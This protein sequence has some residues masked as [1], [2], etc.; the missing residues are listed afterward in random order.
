MPFLIDNISSLLASNITEGSNALKT[1]FISNNHLESKK[2]ITSIKECLSNCSEFYMSVAFITLGGI[3]PLTQILYELEKRNI[4]GYI[5]TTDYLN[6]NDPGALEILSK[7]KNITLKMYLT[8]QDKNKKGEPGFHTKGY[9]FKGNEHNK[10]LYQ[11]IIGSSNLTSTAL[12]LN[13]EWNTQIS[14]S[15]DEKL[16]HDIFEEFKQLWTD[17]N[18]RDYEEVKDYYRHKY[19]IIKAQQK[20]AVVNNVIAF[21]T[22]QLKPNEMQLEFIANLKKLLN[23]RK[24][25]ALFISATGTGKTYASAFAIREIDPQK[26]L[27]VVHREQIA[28][29]SMKSYEIVFNGS[30]NLGLLSGNSK[31]YEDKDIVFATQQT[32]SKKEVYSKFKQDEFD[33]IVIDEAHRI[34]GSTYQ[35][36][37]SYFKPKLLLGM[38]ATPERTDDFDVYKAFDNNI[39]YEIRLQQALEYNFLCPF[40]YFGITDL[41]IDTDD[42]SK[43]SDFR[44]LCRK[45]RLNYI[46]EKLDLYG[47]D[48]DKVKG[49]IFCS[50]NDEAKELANL[51]NASGLY[52]TIALSGTNTQEE[53]DK[54]CEL[55]ESDDPES[56]LDYIFTV[57]IFN[58]GIDIP[59]VNQ[60]VM[61]RPTQSPIVFVQQLGRGLRKT[62][63]KEFVVIIDFIGNY[64]NNFMIPMALSGDRSYK[65]ENLRRFVHEGERII[66]GSSSIS[67]DAISKQKI[68]E[69][70]DSTNFSDLR[71]IKE[72]YKQLKQKVGRVP[73]IKDFELYGQMDVQC[74]FSNKN[75]HSYYTF[76]KKHDP[77]DYKTRIS[78]R[79]EQYINFITWKFAN[80]KRNLE[81]LAFKLMIE[82]EESNLLSKLSKAL[83]RELQKKETINITNILC[84]KYLRGYDFTFTECINGELTISKEFSSLLKDQAFKEILSEVIDYTIDKF[85]KEYNSSADTPFVLYKMY[86][87][88]DVER[89]LCWE[90]HLSNIGG[91][92]HDK[93]TNSFPI[94]VNY[95]KSDDISNTTNYQD[96]F[97]DKNTF[98]WVTR[99]KRSM[100]SPDVKTILN[101]ESNKVTIDLFIRKESASNKNSS[102]IK[103]KEGFKEFYY[104][105][106]VHYKKDTA[107]L[108]TM[109][110]TEEN[111]D[112][113]AVKMDLKLENRV[114]DDI[115][116][117][118]VNKIDYKNENN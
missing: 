93:K 44:Y 118:L 78:P 35:E 109:C 75:L 31:N 38:T 2:V 28:K 20:A 61:L 17:D 58:E 36:L 8:A 101:E 3:K 45:E 87:Y 32:L 24:E 41:Y 7:F 98:T 55:L 22:F 68:F 96:K 59:A 16:I 34:G 113:T 85:N 84:G 14:V 49:L 9:I 66:P 11:I 15:R 112:I 18:A 72:N 110:K 47:H 1:D 90:K 42:D 53:R 100:N 99:S 25:K 57:D 48:G 74:I 70:I 83:G 26:A 82:G 114:R 86:S 76:L 60:V 40:H 64:N 115:F 102:E 54:A 51:F 108:I 39:V 92:W 79:A 111:K 56:Y 67:F 103:N 52:K 65:R 33:V 88:E 106:R 81:P 46:L 6:F 62:D 12:S 77:S 71:L 50:R 105:G 29:K 27:F 37:I 69:S 107:K 73:S 21:D 43:L 5:L 91:Y 97:V 30:K 80:G 89:L 4:K 23:E 63:S 19:E 104:L 94:F 95:H 10:D 117:Y 116:D 13:K